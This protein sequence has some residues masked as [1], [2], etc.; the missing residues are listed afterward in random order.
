M[1]M[2]QQTCRITSEEQALQARASLQDYNI[3]VNYSFVTRFIAVPAMNCAAL[4]NILLKDSTRGNCTWL[5]SITGFSKFEHEDFNF[6][7][8][9][10]SSVL[11]IT[12][13]HY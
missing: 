3:S 4:F 1:T 2:W 7:C 11:L 6:Y 8:M 12:N 10:Q 9:Y 5:H 13:N